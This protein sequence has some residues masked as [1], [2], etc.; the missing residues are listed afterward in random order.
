MYVLGSSDNEPQQVQRPKKK[1]FVLK[2]K[3]T[4]ASTLRNRK[5]LFSRNTI[6]RKKQPNHCESDFSDSSSDDAGSRGRSITESCS[7][8]WRYF[9]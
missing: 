4:L 7:V 1:M 2:R 8:C 9:L 6:P 3:H 5:H